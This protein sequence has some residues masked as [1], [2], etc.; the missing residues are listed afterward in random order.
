MD[1]I[2]SAR[3]TELT[4]AMKNS[5]IGSLDRISQSRL[6]NK[7]EVVLDVD[8]NK[9]RVEIVLHGNSI[10]LDAKAET[11]NMYESIDKAVER[12]ERQLEKKLEK[13]HSHKGAPLGEIEAAHVE[14]LAVAAAEE[15]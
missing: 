5:V 8:H 1:I 2:V 3:H 6:L 15:F 11:D 13:K 10:N 7:A 9:H 12:L 14:A 4:E